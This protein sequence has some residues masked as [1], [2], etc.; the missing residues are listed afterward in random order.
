V[1]P[2]HHHVTVSVLPCGRLRTPGGRIGIGAFRQ[3]H[4]NTCHAHS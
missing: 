2:L 3:D 1:T 4:N